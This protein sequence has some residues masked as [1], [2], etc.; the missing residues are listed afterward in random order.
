ME[1]YNQNWPLT[2]ENKMMSEHEE[3]KYNMY[4]NI[5]S[6]TTKRFRILFNLFKIWKASVFKILWHDLA[7]WIF[8]Y[9]FLRL[10]ENLGA[11]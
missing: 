2:E 1:N 8:F 6:D 3:T 11:I 4:R 9:A 5:Y 10:L 7:L